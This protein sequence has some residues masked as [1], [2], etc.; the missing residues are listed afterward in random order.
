MFA[1][2]VTTRRTWPKAGVGWGRGIPYQG[3]R[4]AVSPAVSRVAGPKYG[5]PG[6]VS[7]SPASWSAGPRFSPV[8]WSARPGFSPGSM[9]SVRARWILSG[10]N[11]AP[12]RGRRSRCLIHFGIDGLSQRRPGGVPGPGSVTSPGGI[13]RPGLS[14]GSMERRARA[15]SGMLAKAQPS[16]NPRARVQSGPDRWS[17]GLSPPG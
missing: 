9:D 15:K 14:P 10:I 5:E 16:M 2:G 17:A 12:G 7:F 8:R 4:I 6:G 13:D 1:I 11:E 3:G